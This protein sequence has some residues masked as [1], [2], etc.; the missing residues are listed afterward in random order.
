MEAVLG[1]RHEHLQRIVLLHLLVQVPL[2]L[3]NEMGH[4]RDFGAVAVML[5]IAFMGNMGLVWAS[6][7]IFGLMGGLVASGT[8]PTTPEIMEKKG[9]GALGIAMGMSVMQISQNL[10]PTIGSPLFG[11]MTISMGW[12]TP[13]LVLCVPLAIVALIALA[14]I[15]VR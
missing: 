14:L 10:A 11:S 15:K 6:V 4:R 9:G 1:V 12:L 8:R 13:S 3:R 5:A 2:Y 7:I